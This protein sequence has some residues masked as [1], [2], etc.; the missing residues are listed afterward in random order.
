M[1]TP[2]RALAF[3]LSL[4]SL[5]LPAAVTS[6]A[7]ER[8]LVVLDESQTN[9]ASNVRLIESLGGKVE[10]DHSEIG[11]LVVTSDEPEF[12][13]YTSQVSEI[14]LIKRQENLTT[15]WSAEGQR[16]LGR[17]ILGVSG[18]PTPLDN[19]S[20]PA[21]SH[22]ARADGE[23]PD[24]ST[25][26]G[27]FLQW[28][29]SIMGLEEVWDLGHFGDPRVKVA[30]VGA[31]ID[32]LHPDLVGT[33]DLDLSKSF[34]PS[35]DI[36]VEQLFPGAH[37][38]AD[39]AF[40]STFVAGQ[41][42]CSLSIFAC[43]APD[44]TLVGVKVLDL[45]EEGTIADLVTGILY[46][47]SIGSDVIVLPFN[48]W[49]LATS[50]EAKI[51]NWGNPEDLPELIAVSRAILWARI[52][53]SVLVTEAA[54]TFEDNPIDADADGLD[55]IIPA[56]NGAIAVGASSSLDTWSTLSNFGFS[57]VDV[58]APGG[59]RLDDGTFPPQELIWGACSGF[60]QSDPF[61]DSCARE[62]QPQFA[63]IIG[64]RTAASQAAGVAALIASR[65]QGRRHGFFIQRKLF[66]TAVDIEAPGFDAF[67]GHGRVDALRGVTQ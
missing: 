4:A 60:T 45:N 50:N 41:I 59:L 5:L 29:L 9:S 35:D 14:S 3:G 44:V 11:V 8:Y 10:R 67:T 34:V 52:R 17:S 12:A 48:Y 38:I 27:F 39:L 15:D 36:L 66:R 57:L 33:V 63:I 30:V 54:M 61:R 49:G 22:Q 56:Q 6:A 1:K 55:V 26:P 25:L 65:Y 16:A 32:Y 7:Q 62:N 43:I 24:P 58:A 18:P 64:P 53:G 2:I 37:P 31:G 23:R 21:L 46:S 47:A 28:N 13:R 20:G 42:A 19:A 40:H 51:Y